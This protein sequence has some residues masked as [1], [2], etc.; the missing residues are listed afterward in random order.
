MRCNGWWRPR[1]GVAWTP[2][3]LF[4]VVF[5]WTPPHTWALG[6]KYRED[7]KRAG[8]PMLPVVATPQHVARQIVIY[9]WVMVAWTLLLLPVTS[10]LY[11]TFALLAGGWFLF[12]AHSLQASVRRGEKTNPMAL[13]HRSNTYLM[14]V[15][16]ALALDSAIGLPTLGLPF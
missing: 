6:M 3:V 14:V 10:W 5:F 16:C 11:G 2:L 7:Y 1:P 13:F 4:G 9:S 12:Y 15:F 8:V